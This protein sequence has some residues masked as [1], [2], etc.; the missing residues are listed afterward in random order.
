MD[1]AHTALGEQLDRVARRGCPHV[2]QTR[3][4][5]LYEIVASVRDERGRVSE[6]GTYIAVGDTEEGPRDRLSRGAWT[7]VK[8][9]PATR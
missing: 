3:S 7:E 6:S 8:S 9:P 5:R 4:G 1:Q 2:V